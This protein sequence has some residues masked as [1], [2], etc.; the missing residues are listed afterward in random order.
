MSEGT[1]KDLTAEP[2]AVKLKLMNGRAVCPICGRQTPTR[3]LPTTILISF[4]LFCKHCR[5]TT[6]V[7][8][9]EP[10]PESLSR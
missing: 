3:I 1:R 4:P 6:L 9:R 10:E 8:Y 7:E 5:R 2:A